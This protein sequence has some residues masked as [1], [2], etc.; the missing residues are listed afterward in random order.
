MEETKKRVLIVDDSPVVRTL[1]KH[2]IDGSGDMEVVGEASDGA[3]GIRKIKELHPDVVT[4]DVQMPRMDGPRAIQEIMRDCPVPIILCSVLAIE[5]APV[6]L[7]AL[8]NGAIDFVTKPKSILGNTAGMASALLDKL[9]AA[10]SANWESMVAN[11]EEL[12]PLSGQKPEAD[13]PPKRVIP[14]GEK[15]TDLVVIGASTGGPR[16]ILAV[17]PEFPADFPASIV[18]ALQDTP[19]AIVKLL[20]DQLV[21]ACPMPLVLVTKEVSLKPGTIYLLNGDNHA[22]VVRGA[23][24]EAKL[25]VLERVGDADQTPSLNGLFSSVAVAC[26]SRCLG[27]ILTGSGKDGALGIKKIKQAGGK[28]IAEDRKTAVIFEKPSTAI[29]MQ[30]IDR[31]MSS[32]NVVDGVLELMAVAADEAAAAR[33]KAKNAS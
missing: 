14:A 2:V 17:L 10:Q 4:M 20:S 5:G 25:K 32:Q 7:Q 31:V 13:G 24:A 23:E 12:P 33:E 26:G 18:V 3:E 1:L 29:G 28:T 22:M 19:T 15:A 6:V 9:R 21:E 27:I 30:V 8:Q 11:A 16:T